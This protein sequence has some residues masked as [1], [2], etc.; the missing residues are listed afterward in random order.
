MKYKK[1]NSHKICKPLREM[2][3]VEAITKLHTSTEPI[4]VQFK[5]DW[6]GACK[7]ATPE[8]QKAS[9]DL[10]GEMEVIQVDFDK[11][12]MLASEFGIEV[13]PTVA[14]IHRG[15]VVAKEEGAVKAK[16][17]KKL[18]H[19]FLKKNGWKDPWAPSLVPLPFD[20]KES[21]GE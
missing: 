15:R 6:C 21:S 17:Y 12:G 3:I 20:F 10:E 18:A 16:D 7:V 9:C 13:L 1:R 4:M 19:D 11:A 8:V 5:A 2:P 14:V